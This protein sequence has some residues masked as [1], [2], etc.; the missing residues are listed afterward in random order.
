MVTP[1]R[2]SAIFRSTY[3]QLFKSACT[4]RNVR[5]QHAS[6]TRTDLAGFTVRILRHIF[7]R[8]CNEGAG[9]IQQTFN[10]H[11]TD[12]HILVEMLKACDFE[13]SD[14]VARIIL[15]EMFNK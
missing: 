15:K 10:R 13:D 5:M 14:P 12:Y 1:I 3:S 11:S 4:I 8:L 2:I 9:D 7:L 6:E